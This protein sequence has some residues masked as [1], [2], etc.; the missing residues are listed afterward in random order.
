M[1]NEKVIATWYYRFVRSREQC[2]QTRLGW[3]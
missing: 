1:E 3:I 2:V